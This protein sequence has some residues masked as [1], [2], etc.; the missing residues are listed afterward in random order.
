MVTQIT[1]SA[2]TSSMYK[3]L[4]KCPGALVFRKIISRCIPKCIIKNSSKKSEMSAIKCSVIQAIIYLSLVYFVTPMDG[5]QTPK[6]TWIGLAKGSFCVTDR[7]LS[8]I[9]YIKKYTFTPL[10]H[11][12]TPF[13]DTGVLRL[14]LLIHT[15]NLYWFYIYK[16]YKVSYNVWMSQG[17]HAVEPYFYI[18]CDR[19]AM[20]YYAVEPYWYI[21]V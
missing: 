3:S 5:W 9:K 20:G 6:I 17:C 11:K 12:L 7:Q 14:V 4:C 13:S 8:K 16:V 21:S 2:S 19:V 18:L 15:F 10:T 1:H